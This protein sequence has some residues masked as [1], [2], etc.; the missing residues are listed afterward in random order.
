MRCAVNNFQIR[1]TNVNLSSMMPVPR[2]KLQEDLHLTVTLKMA[3]CVGLVF[4]KCKYIY[5]KL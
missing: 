2:N 5:N 1:A 4:L 3:M